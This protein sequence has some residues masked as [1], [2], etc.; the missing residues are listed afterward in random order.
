MAPQALAEQSL[1]DQASAHATSAVALD[2]AAS[3]IA[4][5]RRA[6]IADRYA[7][8]SLKV[9]W[10]RLDQISPVADAWRELAGRALEPNAF[11]EPSFALPAAQVYGE[12]VGA[13]LVWS[14]AKPRRLVGFFPARIESR[15]Y[16]IKLPLLVGWTHP[17]GPLGL[18]LVERDGAEPIIA[19]WLRHV[20]MD[21]ALPAL[22][23]LPF[24]PAEGGFGAALADIVRRTRMPVADFNRHRRALLEPVDDR[25]F[26][27]EH[28]IGQ[29][30]HKELRRHWRRLSDTG[31]V[32]FTEATEP[33]MV[34]AAL[35]D[36][37]SLEVGGWKGR[38]GAAAAEH[39][40]MR[41]FIRVAVTGLAAEGKASVERILLDGRA[42]AAA[43]VLR[44]GSRAWFWKIAYDEGFAR[45]SPGVMLSVAVTD[46][47]LDD[48]R[49]ARTDSC[50]T[51][52]H[53]MI[54]HLWRERLALCD[55]LIA[56]RP[57]APFALARRLEW[58]RSASL[59]GAKS[60]RAFFWRGA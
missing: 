59:A 23:L 27:V 51:A 9:E 13:V 14:E 26:Y 60:L 19:A 30:Q 44:S 3:A 46:D 39:E 5:A 33:A 38:A 36:F 15:R 10:L 29:H 25:I 24:L 32:L 2:G 43:I 7:V 56:V 16:G 45:Y 31:A 47:L 52:N 54:D 49:I 8:D 11:Y 22:M 6:V 53:P 17:Y 42:I 37:F 41:R 55:R 12:D 1:A 21:K 18:P 20:S 57:E 35:E 34:A 40:D 50:A 4:T 48:L 58:V 28:S